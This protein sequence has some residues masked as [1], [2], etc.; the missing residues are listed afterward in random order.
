MWG[1][2][3]PVLSGTVIGAILVYLRPGLRLR[4][5]AALTVALGTIATVV[6]GEFSVSWGYFLVDVLLVA[7]SALV[8]SMMLAHKLGW[9]PSRSTNSLYLCTDD[10]EK[11]E[12]H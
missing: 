1:E 11:Q 9:T 3:L 2:L 4:I 10:N 6:S 5:G 8:S 12:S 7:V